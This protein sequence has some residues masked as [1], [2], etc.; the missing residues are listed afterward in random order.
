MK[1]WLGPVLLVRAHGRPEAAVDEDDLTQGRRRKLSLELAGKY[2][3]LGVS[4]LWLEL[5]RK[6]VRG[7]LMHAVDMRA[8]GTDTLPPSTAPKAD[9]QSV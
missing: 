7:L 4:G 3:T 2:V 6:F 1:T 8:A 9:T 5:R